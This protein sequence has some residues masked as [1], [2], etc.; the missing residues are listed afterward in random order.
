M[1]GFGGLILLPRTG[2]LKN[3][4]TTIL[5]LWLLLILQAQSQESLPRK[6]PEAERAEYFHAHYTKY[7]YQIPMRDT[8]RLFTSVYLPKDVSCKYPILRFRT[9]YT[10]RPY[11]SDNYIDLDK[12]LEQ[13]AKEGFIFAAQDVRGSNKSEGEY[14]NVRP[15]LPVKHS[16]KEVDESTDTYDTID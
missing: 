6:T 14:V 15:Y 10:V 9:P 16:P 5:S 11:G 13:F 3:R 2:L 12:N 8:V 7:E 4:L 1:K